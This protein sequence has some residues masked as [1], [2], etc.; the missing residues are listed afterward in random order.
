MGLD[1]RT[2]RGESTR[3]WYRGPLTPQPTVRAEAVD[4]VLPL[5]NT[6]DQLRKLVPDGREDVSL[7]ALFEIGRLLTLN[8]P[9]LVA[10]LM[11]WRRD[12]FGAAR[13][14][15]L[16][17]ALVGSVVAK[18][19][20]GVVG[21]RNALED[22]VRTSVVGSFAAMPDGAL[23][24]S[25]PLVTSA[26]MP[27]ELAGLGAADVLGGL[28]VSA[29]A[30]SRAAK[31]GGVDGLGAVP[32]AVGQAPTVPVTE[33]ER[34]LAALSGRAGPP[35]RR[36]R[37]QRPQ[38]V[39]RATEGGAAQAGA[40]QGHPRPAHRRGR[41]TGAGRWPARSRHRRTEGLTWS[42]GQRHTSGP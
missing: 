5:A 7:A 4:G 12:L 31:L 22:L 13:A 29:A 39:R 19:G 8:K 36:P 11:Q 1:H 21:G 28:G 25:A 23:A 32:V 3:S 18:A 26:R 24:R 6:G 42:S 2:R 10:E 34:A 17:D 33:D 41:G 20:L 16:A 37:A 30:M 9:T 40:P 15:E 38:G 35:G 14:R 27:E